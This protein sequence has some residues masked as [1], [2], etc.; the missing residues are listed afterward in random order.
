MLEPVYR[1]ETRFLQHLQT[2]KANIDQYKTEVGASA[3]DIAEITADADVFDFLITASNLA[4]EFKTTANGIKRQFFSAKTEP[5]VG[6][7]M[8]PPALVPPAPIVAGAVKRARE[9]DQRFLRAKD[10]SEA[11]IIALDLRG[12]ESAGIS[13]D[14]VQPAIEAHAA[15][16]GYE[17]ALVVSNRRNADM[18]DAQIQR[19]GGGKWETVKSGTG[20]SINVVIEPT[21]EGKPEQL[22]VRVQ[23]RKNDANYGVPS[24][25]TYVTVNP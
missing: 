22:L 7:F 1:S 21:A 2:Q 15:A 24:D 9:R 10:I 16:S 23:L 3:A 13:P 12:E 25:P 11:A 5:P 19:A 18:Y 20:K 14:D 6:A 17:F 8:N 4:D